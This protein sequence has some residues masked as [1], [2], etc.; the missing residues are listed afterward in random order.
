MGLRSLL[1]FGMIALP[2]GA[3]LGL[4]IGLDAHRSATGQS[5]LFQDDSVSKDQYCQKAYGITP[6]SI[7]QQYTCESFQRFL[8][9]IKPPG[10]NVSWQD[11]WPETDQHCTIARTSISYALVRLMQQHQK[12]VHQIVRSK[13]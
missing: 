9:G 1:S 10:F 3:T 13:C 2:I 11:N 8:L 5:P 7:G 12:L 4:L 6:T